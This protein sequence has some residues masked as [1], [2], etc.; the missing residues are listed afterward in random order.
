VVY[1][2]PKEKPALPLAKE[3]GFLKLAALN[4]DQPERK[5]FTYPVTV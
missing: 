1:G 4:G 2:V 3:Y 5:S